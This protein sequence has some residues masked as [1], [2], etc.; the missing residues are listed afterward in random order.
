MADITRTESSALIEP[1]SE[2]PEAGEE[3]LNQNADIKV[4]KR[5]WYILMVFTLLNA[6]GNII[7]NTWPPIQETCQLVF[8]W[9]DTNVLIIGA[10]QALGSII[11]V[12]PS[13]WLLDTKGKFHFTCNLEKLASDSLCIASK[14]Q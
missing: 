3:P 11:S 9:T 14:F 12:V 4:Y 8:H 10:L 5:R 1:T 2:E 7:W 13:S 6:V